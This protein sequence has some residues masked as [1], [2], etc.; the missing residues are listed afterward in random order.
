MQ[1]QTTL[2]LWCDRIIEGGWLL[3]IT[4]IPIYFNLLSARH[5]EPDKATTLRAIVLVMAAAGLIRAL[6]LFAQRNDATR[7]SNDA[8]Q[9]PDQGNPLRRLWQRF[10]AIPL[11]LPVLLYALVFLLTTFTS[12]VPLTSF[13][14]SYQRLQG[15]YTNLSYIGLFV[16]IVAT[17]RRRDQLERLITVTLVTSL[18]VAGYGV[19]QHFQLDPLPWRGDVVTRVASTMGNSIF[20]AAYMIMVLPFALY[21]LLGSL[22]AARSAPAPSNARND[23]LWALAYVLLIAGTLALILAVIKFGAAVRT[24]DLRYWWVFPGGVVAATALWTLLTMDLEQ[25]GA[26]GRGGVPLW[27]GLVFGGYLLL[28]GAM[29]ALSSGAQVIDERATLALDWWIWLLFSLLAVVGF[30]ALAFALPRQAATSRLS[31][32]LHAL[33][34]LVL[35]LTLLVATFFTQSR[36]PWIGLGFGLFV[37]FFLLLWQALRNAR[38]QGAAALVTRL[39]VVLWSWVGLTLL[40]GSFLIV[41]NVSDAPFFKQLRDVPYIGRMGRLLEIDSGTGLVRRLIWVGDE[42]AGGAVALITS[43][44]LR[45]IIGWGPES[46]FVSFNRFYPPGLANVESRGASPDRSHQAILDELVTKGILGLISYFFVLLSSCVLCWRLMRRSDD[47]RWQVFFIACLSAIVAHFTEGLTGIPIVST[48]MM[49][50]I[51]LGLVV[52]GGMLAGHYTL[53]AVAA[54]AAEPTAEAVPADTA[55]SGKRKTPQPAGRR[56]AVARSATASRARGGTGGY[57]T[58]P[59]QTSPAALLFYGMV[60]LLTMGA[61]WWFNLNPVYA[62]M[63]FQQGQAY[64]EQRGAGLNGLILAMDD[65]LA[66]IRGNPRE[67]FYYLNLGRILMNIA[68]QLRVQGVPLGQ[69]DSNASIDELLRLQDAAQIQDFVQRK[70]PIEMLSYAQAVLQRA[71]ELNPLNKDHYANL[72]RLNNFW[73]SWTQDPTRLQESLSWYEKVNEIAPQDVTL[74]NERASITSLRGSYAQSVGNAEEAQQYYAEAERLLQHSKA[75]DPRYVDTDARLG[76]LMRIQDRFAEAT[77]LYVSVVQR[78]PHQ[79]D[80]S[81]ERIIADMRDQPEL[82][83]KLRDA[84]NEQAT[85]RN[86]ALLYAISGLISIRVGDTE[87]AVQ[88]YTQA[89]QIQPQSIEYRRNYTI[90][91]SDTQRYD[92]ALSEARNTLA[93][94]QGQAG[95]EA[96]IAQLQALIS[97][98]EQKAAGGE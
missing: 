11:A 22:H 39:R 62:D 24:A 66:T 94:A 79:L 67:D 77:D 13:W 19:L 59:T 58:R 56:G 52:V 92:Q 41:F 25:G 6:E 5:F 29:F 50:W 8:T 51:T 53:G 54:P 7:P 80:D 32:Q 27:P 10:Y 2:S 74:I 87:Q 93:L 97:F 1:R 70:T 23:L 33:G 44:P 9:E 35:T 47:W 90:V 37:F 49:F 46:M 84:Y 48:L 61:V 64:S 71:R 40:V 18:A 65:Y 85:Q 28:L 75:L 98:L 17:L 15:T 91:L 63:R 96:E 86:D 45:M 30:Y 31:H 3:A 83:R 21:R 82:L 89:V 20:V 60:L 4:L 68:D 57:R 14:G 69:P 42:H 34:A 38:A 78:R 73:Y 36:G 43:D 12:V 72:G 26:D 55:A 16:L 88:E 81:V 95:R 76:D